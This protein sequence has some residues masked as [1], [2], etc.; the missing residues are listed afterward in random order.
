[1]SSKHKLTV[2][3]VVHGFF[4]QHGSGAAPCDAAREWHGEEREAQTRAEAIQCG[5]RADRAPCSSSSDE[6]D[7]RSAEWR[8]AGVLLVN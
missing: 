4:S 8:R 1:M 5:Q 3:L 6:V 7:E 2:L